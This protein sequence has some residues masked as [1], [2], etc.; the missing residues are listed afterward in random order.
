MRG[1]PPLSL[2][3]VREHL[4]GVRNASDTGHGV[5]LTIAAIIDVTRAIA[6]VCKTATLA[7]RQ[8]GKYRLLDLNG[9]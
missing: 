8:K 3:I 4:F 1:W 2:S 7:H 9:R 5:K 6:K